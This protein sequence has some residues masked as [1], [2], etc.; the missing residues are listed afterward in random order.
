MGGAYYNYNK[1]SVGNWPT[2]LHN[3]VHSYSIMNIKLF[4]LSILYVSLLS[5]YKEL[6]FCDKSVGILVIGN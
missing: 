2:S 6:P 3:T 4:P 5:P 1:V